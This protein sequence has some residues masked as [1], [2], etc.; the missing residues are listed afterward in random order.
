MTLSAR[1]GLR[2]TPMRPQAWERRFIA[3]L[4]LRR[5]LGGRVAPL[6]ARTLSASRR[7]SVRAGFPPSSA[8][9]WMR[10]LSGGSP[11]I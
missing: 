5:W 1:L 2:A 7:W 6:S 3:W 4:S 10:R 8:I 9:A 11:V